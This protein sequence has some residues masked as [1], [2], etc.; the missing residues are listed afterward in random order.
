[1]IERWKRVGRYGRPNGDNVRIEEIDN[2][3]DAFGFTW[4]SGSA[5]ERSVCSEIRVENA[6]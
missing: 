5:E 2:N 6:L 4:A 1:M 3:Q